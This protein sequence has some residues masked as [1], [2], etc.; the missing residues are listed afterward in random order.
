[1]N[2]RFDPLLYAK[3][4]AL[5]RSYIRTPFPAG[6]LAL[7]AGYVFSSMVLLFSLEAGL[8]FLGITAGLITLLTVRRCGGVMK[9]GMGAWLRE[10]IAFCIAPVVLLGALIYGSVKFKSVLIF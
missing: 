8:G 10:W 9:N 5:Y 2:R 3:H 1:M 6:I 7:L 4:K